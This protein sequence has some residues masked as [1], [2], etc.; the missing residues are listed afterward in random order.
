MS[1]DS[2]KR[3]ESNIKSDVEELKSVVSELKNAIIDIRAAISELENPFNL[4]RVLSANR[5]I[6]SLSQIGEA[7]KA[8]KEKDV[9]EIA[10]EEKRKVDELEK[11]KEKSTSEFS[12]SPLRELHISKGRV[13]KEFSKFK[14]SDFEEGFSILK[15]TWSL[16]DAGMTR[17]DIL[18]ITKYCELMGYLPPGS[19][20]LVDYVI[21]PMVKARLGG[22]TLDE[23]LLIIY[24]AV[25]ASGLNLEIKRLEDIAFS[26][27]RKIL[28]KIDS[29][30][31]IKR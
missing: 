12:K 15:W 24:S 10:V 18:G 29:N 19:S 7:G 23:F 30:D 8:V 2:S 20:Q 13:E 26:L 9:H 4:L 17:D 16:M 5:D 6:K 3:E 27:L 1:G 22:L 14:V 25:K 11:L 21:E 31:V 28:K